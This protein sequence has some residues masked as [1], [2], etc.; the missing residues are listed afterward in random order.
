MGDEHSVFPWRDWKGVPFWTTL[1]MPDYASSSGSSGDSG[2]SDD[3]DQ[4]GHEDQAGVADEEEQK[5]QKEE[6]PG[7]ESTLEGRLR[8]VF[9]A[10][11]RRQVD[12]S[13][14]LLTA[15][16]PAAAALGVDEYGWLLGMLRMNVVGVIVPASQL[17]D[18]TGVDDE[19]AERL[20]GGGGAA[21]GQAV[22]FLRGLG[23]FGLHSCLNHGRQA[24]AEVLAT[25]G[26][27]GAA[28][29]VR[30]SRHVAAGEELLIDYLP[31]SHCS[32]KDASPVEVHDAE[33]RARVLWDQY[34]VREGEEQTDA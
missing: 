29:L 11:V 22:Q 28:V 1:S 9:E 6:P 15:V 8:A 31:D 5:E 25:A 19:S 24:N 26:Q 21:G 23:I 14:G 20:L 13:L 17:V 2:D 32:D 10:A 12:E 33:S 4:S 34:R 3:S 30:T 18:S 16:L 27:R 7:P